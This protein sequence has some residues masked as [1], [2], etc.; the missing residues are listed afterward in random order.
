MALFLGY[1]TTAGRYAKEPVCKQ[2]R[3]AILDDFS[4][5]VGDSL[6][7]HVAYR[8]GEL[9]IE[10]DFPI[11]TVEVICPFVFIVKGLE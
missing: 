7:V 5:S 2:N 3:E 8:F 1:E 9:T 10:V 4:G 11:P 6:P